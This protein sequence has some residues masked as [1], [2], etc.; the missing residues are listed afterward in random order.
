MNGR[1]RS[2]S[3]PRRKS[4]VLDLDNTLVHSFD[5]CTEYKRL[6]LASP[7]NYE[8]RSHVYYLDVC[9][10]DGPDGSKQEPIS[11]KKSTVCGIKRPGLD[12]FLIN[13]FDTFEHVFVW[14]AGLRKYVEAICDDI[15]A[16]IGEPTLIYSRENCYVD[17][18]GNIKKPLSKLIKEHPEYNLSMK[19]LLIVD[20]RKD[21]AFDDN[22]QNAII[23]PAFA[24]DSKHLNLELLKKQD[25]ALTDLTNWF[26]NHRISQVSD[27]RKLDKTKIF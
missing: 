18:S 21:Y 12:D 20:D 25:T 17:D 26:S 9:D 11:C 2:T 1:N 16:N 22:P 5:N 15:F 7:K 23:I 27:V 14:S 6:N 3:H 13:C 24:D 4:L 19:D 8:I 10:I